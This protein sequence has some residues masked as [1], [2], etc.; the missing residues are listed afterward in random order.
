MMEAGRSEKCGVRNIQPAFAGS[1]GGGQGHKPRN[2]HDLWK[3][4]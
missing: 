2:A 4:E 1:E 3:L